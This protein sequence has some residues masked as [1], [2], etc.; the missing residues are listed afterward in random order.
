MLLTTGNKCAISKAHFGRSRQNPLR[1][2]ARIIPVNKKARDGDYQSC[3]DQCSTQLRRQLKQLHRL[4]SAVR[5]SLA[6]SKKYNSKAHAQLQQLWNTICNAHG[7]KKGFTAWIS[8][9]LQIQPSQ[10]LPSHDMLVSIKDT[11]SEWYQYN[12]NVAQKA[13]LAIQKIELSEDWRRGGKI[14]FSKIKVC[15]LLPL[16]AIKT[17]VRCPIRRVAWSKE[18]RSFLPCAN[19]FDL[20]PNLPIGFQTQNARIQRISDKG[21]HLD[22]KVHLLCYAAENL[23]VQQEQTCAQPEDMHRQLF[24]AWNVYFQRDPSH[25]IDEVPDEMCQI[26][27]RVPRQQLADLPPISVTD[28][29]TALKNTKI[30]SS[31]GSDGFSTLDLRKLPTNLLQMLALILQLVEQKG[32]WPERWTLAKT[33]C[34][35]K[36]EEPSSPFDVRPVTVMAKIYRLWGHIRGKQVTQLISANI[37]PEVAGVCKR[38]SSDLIALLIATK[39]EDAHREASP[40]GGIVLDLMKCY[41]TVPRGALLRVLE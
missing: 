20:D 37:P 39:I 23:H 41:N 29:Q 13:K 15:E 6:L 3:M 17:T 19:P 2:S 24:Q 30:A 9:H 26:V 11:Y 28:L 8:E 21:I 31:R 4:Q 7:F 22:R 14:A 36:C 27:D 18:G 32:V 5:Q 34:L 16:T 12:E 1:T 33:L 10:N 38:V 25:E 35:P 40:L